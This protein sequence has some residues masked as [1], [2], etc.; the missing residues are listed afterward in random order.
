MSATKS[1]A[2]RTPVNLWGKS[3][4]LPKNLDIGF[5][6]SVSQRNQDTISMTGIPSIN[7][8]NNRRPNAT[9]L[10]N[11]QVLAA[12]TKQRVE[13]LA[14]N[15]PGHYFGPNGDFLGSIQDY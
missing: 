5:A 7:E 10:E 3:T 2:S 9:S 15:P 6:D 4:N 1:K 11:A 8:L 14:I 12:V 13:K